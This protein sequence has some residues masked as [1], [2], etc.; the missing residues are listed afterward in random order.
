MVNVNLE[1]EI[2]AA[3]KYQIKVNFCDYGQFLFNIL[4]QRFNLKTDIKSEDA[5]ITQEHENTEKLK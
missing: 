1:K 4:G 3:C 5:Q 2:S